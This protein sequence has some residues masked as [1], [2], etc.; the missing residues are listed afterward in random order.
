MRGALALC[1]L[2]IV[3]RTARQQQPSSVNPTA[4]S[5][6]EEQLLRELQRSGTQITIP[7][8]RRPAQPAGR[9]WRSFHQ[10]TLRWIGG[11]AILGV[12]G[13]AARVL[14]RARLASSGRR[15]AEA[16]ALQRLRALRPLADRASFIILAL[17]GFN[18]TFGTR[19]SPR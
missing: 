17:T 12:L 8:A 4:S 7:D 6:R 1:W 15:R 9:D 16:H 18:I 5:V 10:K 2:A 19:C 13:R 3:R 11:L 14:P